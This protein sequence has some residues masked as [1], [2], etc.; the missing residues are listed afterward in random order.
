MTDSNLDK[1]KF[2]KL[3]C[4]PYAG[5]S[6]SIFKEWINMLAEHGI[7]VVP[8]EYPGH[9]SR[10]HE[11][12]RFDL[13]SL[14]DDIINFYQIDG[15]EPFALFGHS[16]G[17]LVAFE[18]ARRVWINNGCSPVRLFVGARN[19]PHLFR[20]PPTSVCSLGEDDFL[21]FVARLGGIPHEIWECPELRGIFVP[22]LRADFTLHESYVFTDESPLDCPITVFGGLGDEFTS[23]SGLREWSRHTTNSFVLR[24]FQGDH[25]FI[26]GQ[27]KILTHMIMKDLL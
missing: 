13:A 23:S 24:M 22:I 18:V 6:A 5:G 9:G 4:F 16:L 1:S 3:F 7:S 19:A 10:L 21:R 15:T 17:S 11:K 2:I 12:L 25:F 14:A 8:I 26:T 27:Q 20:S